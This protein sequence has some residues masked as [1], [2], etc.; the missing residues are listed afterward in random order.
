MKETILFED[1]VNGWSSGNVQLSDD[2]TN[3]DFLSFSFGSSHDG[4][5]GSNGTS[6]SF[7]S[8]SDFLSSGIFLITF[9]FRRGFEVKVNSEDYTTLICNRRFA[10]NESSDAA[11]IVY[12]IKGY[13]VSSGSSGGG[14]VDL[15][16]TNNY[17]DGINN[18]LDEILKW[19][20]KIYNQVVLGNII[21]GADLLNDLFQ[22]E[23]DDLSALG[24]IAQTKFPFS[25]AVD[26]LAILT[27]LEAEPQAPVFE[28][29]FRAD[30]GGPTG[31]SV[32][33]VF[34]LDF[35]MFEDAVEVLRWWLSIM[36]IF[37]LVWMTPRFLDV[38]GDLTGG[39]KK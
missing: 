37:A 33:E 15:T 35:T 3:Y 1:T 25:L 26:I 8:T 18:T 2:W 30:F 29:P 28:I 10:D 11:P 7:V 38:G 4:G 31:I 21:E 14:T 34:V 36:W 27:I 24:E 9:Y 6:S 32:D 13:K 12:V 5:Y 23:L 39:G 19:V 22:Q 16:D 17:L 20:K